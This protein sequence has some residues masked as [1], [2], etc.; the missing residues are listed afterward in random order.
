MNHWSRREEDGLGMREIL[1]DQLGI[2]DD[3]IEK[4]DS[5]TP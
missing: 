4:K 2:S 1:V 3:N 5:A